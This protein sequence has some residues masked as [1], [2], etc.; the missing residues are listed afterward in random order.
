MMKWLRSQSILR[1]EVVLL[2]WLFVGSSGWADTL[3]L[4]EDIVSPLTGIQQAI[5]PDILDDVRKVLGPVIL[6]SAQVVFV[7]GTP[8]SCPEHLPQIS[9]T[10]LRL[11]YLP[12]YRFICVYRI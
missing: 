9:P 2:V 1:A 10:P 4:S 7:A 8:L 3:D 6:E 5:E 11:S 12:L